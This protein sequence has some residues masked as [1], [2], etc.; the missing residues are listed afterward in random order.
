MSVFEDKTTEHLLQKQVFD[1][2]NVLEYKKHCFWRGF[3]NPW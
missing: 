3:G 1:E 2:Q